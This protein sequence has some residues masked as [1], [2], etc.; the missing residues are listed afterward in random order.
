MIFFILLAFAAVT[1]IIALIESVA[2]FAEGKWQMKRRNALLI[3]GTLA[4]AIGLVTVFSFNIWES[5]KLFG[6]TFFDLLDFL[7]ANIMLPLGGLFI[8]IF[9]GWVM[10]NSS[11]ED[12][13][14]ME[15]ATYFRV[16]KFLV[17]F[18]TPVGVFLIFLR[19]LGI[20]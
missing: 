9:V 13:I 4:W 17:K 18:V 3:F 16:W 8:A 10:R 12:E 7:T 14:A 20:I 1:S 2:R 5:Y 15:S 19:V 6:K 11:V